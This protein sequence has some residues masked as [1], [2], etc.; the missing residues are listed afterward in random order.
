VDERRG[1]AS[2]P[3]PPFELDERFPS[4]PWTGF[5][6]QPPLRG[7]HWMELRLTFSNGRLR[8]DGRDRIGLFTFTGSYDVRDGTCRWVKRYVGAHDVAY[9]ATTRARASGACGTSRL[10]CAAASTSGRSAWPTPPRRSR[11]RNR[12]RSK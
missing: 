5:F 9:A 10:A 11:A 7:R 8:G 4:G 2:H 3:E 6:L 1:E 12:K